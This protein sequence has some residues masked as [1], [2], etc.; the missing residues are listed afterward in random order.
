M[1]TVAAHNTHNEDK[2]MAAEKPKM[3]ALVVEPFKTFQH[4]L[5]LKFRRAGFDVIA[6]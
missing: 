1:L 3:Q 2:G 6:R 5:G 4:V